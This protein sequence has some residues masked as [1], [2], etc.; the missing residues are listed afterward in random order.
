M[1]S[2]PRGSVAVATPSYAPHHRD[3]MRINISTVETLGVPARTR[4]ALTNGGEHREP[5]PDRCSRVGGDCGSNGVSGLTRSAWLGG[6]E[7]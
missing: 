7:R 6:K 4:L 1:Q 2:R 3:R 5:D